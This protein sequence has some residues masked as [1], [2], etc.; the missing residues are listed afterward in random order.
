MIQ[1]D[2][3]LIKKYNRS[4]PRYTSYPTSIQFASLTHDQ[5][6]DY[7]LS[8]LS[9]PKK[10]SIY[11]HL[12]FCQS[13]CWYCG[14]TTVISKNPDVSKTYVDNLKIEIEKTAQMVHPDSVVHQLHYGGGTP[15]FLRESELVDLSNTI[16]KHFKFAEDAEISIEIDPRTVSNSQIIALKS[17]GFNRASLGVQDVNLEVQQ[18]IHRIQTMDQ[19]AHAMEWLRDA[20]FESV[21]VDLIYGLPKQTPELFQQTLEAVEFLDPDRIALY[22]YA[23]VPWV[24]PAQKLIKDEDLPEP[25]TKISLF[26]MALNQLQKMGWEYIGMDHFAKPNDELAI[27]RRNGTL[28]RNF[29][30]YSTKAGLDMLSFG[31]SGIAQVGNAYL[32]RHRIVQ[33]WTK[34]VQE[35]GSTYGK[36]YILNHD[37]QVRKELIM[38]IM[39]FRPIV[40]NKLSEKYDINAR[41]Y[42]KSEISELAS[43]EEDE[44][45][46]T[47]EIGFEITDKGRLF[48]RNISMVFDAYLKKSEVEAEPIFSKTI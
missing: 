18:A 12:P 8:E 10:L 13:M 38:D 26:Q 11:V 44:L 15:T 39:C 40:W 17:V 27:A 2:T 29:Q 31:M 6:N 47:N 4:G 48:V 3:D 19:N 9:E 1:L 16:K 46:I 14:C 20:G 42:F 7:L 28:H 43:F 25:P 24:K 33:H 41:D 36:G 30:G 5:A 45:L 34:G 35:L 37:D 32:Q 22:S 23:H 21:N